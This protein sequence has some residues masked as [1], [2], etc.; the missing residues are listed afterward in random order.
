M[1]DSRCIICGEKKNGLEVKEDYIIQ[2]IRWVKKN[3]TKDEK[4]HRLV[5]CKDDFAKY[6]KSRDSYKRKQ[7]IY[8]ALGVI[9]TIFLAGVSGPRVFSALLLGTGVTMFMYLLSQLSYMPDVYIPAINQEP[10]LQKKSK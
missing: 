10:M 5:V 2:I 1:K 7:A 3:I 4:G 6:K 9:F 8:I